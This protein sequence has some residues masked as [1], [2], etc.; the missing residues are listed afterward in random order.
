MFYTN[1]SP[2]LSKLYCLDNSLFSYIGIL[3]FASH[4]T[5]IFYFHRTTIVHK[6]QNIIKHL[7][8]NEGES[9]M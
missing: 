6:S 9:H 5:M 1:G 8:Q 3:K 7:T 2:T 4:R